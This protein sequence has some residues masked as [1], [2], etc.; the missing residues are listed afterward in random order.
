[1]SV[2]LKQLLE[3]GCHFGHQSRRWNPKMKP[4]LFTERDGVHVFDLVKTKEGLDAATEYVKNLVLGGGVIV[5]VGSKRQAASIVK[6][7]A[8]RVGVPYVTERWLGGSFTN[9]GEMR[10]RV[11]RLVSLKQKREAGELKS[12]TK[13]EQLLFDR[14]IAK[15]ERFFGGVESLARVPDAV[16]VVDTHKEDT[17]VREARRLGVKI[18]GIVDSNGNPQEVDY[19][20]PANDDAVKSIELIVAEVANAVALGK[21]IPVKDSNTVEEHEEEKKPKSKKKVEKKIEDTAEEPEEV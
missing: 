15:L 5:F 20:I 18:V 9:F 7:N 8:K 19:L 12:Y 6:D 3:A 13:K 10:K 17:A 14:E 16:F 4:Y 11:D 1:M 21:G 2:T